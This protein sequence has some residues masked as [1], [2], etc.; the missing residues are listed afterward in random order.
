M[1][2]GDADPMIR[3]VVRGGGFWLGAVW[4]SSW[5]LELFDGLD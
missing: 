4:P 2:I 1:W 5:T 3:R